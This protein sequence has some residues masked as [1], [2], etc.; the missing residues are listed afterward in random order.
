V[1]A[2]WLQAFSHVPWSGGRRVVGIIEIGEGG[3]KRRTFGD[4]RRKYH[5]GKRERKKNAP[6]YVRLVGPLSNHFVRGRGKKRVDAGSG[7]E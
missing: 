3:P 2:T 4:G 6:Y 5:E 7:V 1:K